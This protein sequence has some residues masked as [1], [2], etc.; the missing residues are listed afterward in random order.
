MQDRLSDRYPFPL[1]SQRAPPSCLPLHRPQRDCR[2]QS[3]HPGYAQAQCIPSQRMF[4]L[5]DRCLPPRNWSLIIRCDPSHALADPPGRD[6]EPV[7]RD[8]T[9]R[10]S[11]LGVRTVQGTSVLQILLGG[12]QVR[13]VCTDVAC[14]LLAWCRHPRVLLPGDCHPVSRGVSLTSRAC[15]PTA[16]FQAG[17]VGR[18][19][20]W[21]Q[22]GVVVNGRAPS[23]GVVQT[24]GRRRVHH[25]SCNIIALPTRSEPRTYHFA[26]RYPSPL[27]PELPKMRRR[28]LDWGFAFR[29]QADGRS[30]SVRQGTLGR[31]LAG[32]RSCTG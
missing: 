16:S 12:G 3:S 9:W 5:I 22:Q 25:S 32:G 21:G 17:R 27:Y 15:S 19:H 7:R 18:R 26:R 11:L 10:R 28:V 20:P 23:R 29:R 4:R 31:P 24:R 2:P 13:Q 14:D 30:G 1:R 6:Q 8:W